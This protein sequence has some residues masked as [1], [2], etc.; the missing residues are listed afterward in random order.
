MIFSFGIVI[1]IFCPVFGVFWGFLYFCQYRRTLL[2]ALIIGVAIAAAFYGYIPDSSSDV[3][4]HIA[5]LKYYS[6]ISFFNCFDAGHYNKMYVWDIWCWLIAQMNNENMLQ[7]SGA[8]VGYTVSVY[9]IFDACNKYSIDRKT[10]RTLFLLLLCILP[11]HQFVCGLR[12]GNAFIICCLAFYL[13]IRDEKRNPVKPILCLIVAVLIHH[14][15]LMLVGLFF[16]F[17]ITGKKNNYRV[18]IIIFLS[19]LGIGLI[20]S[21][22]LRILPS[23]GNVA[24]SLIRESSLEATGHINDTRTWYVTKASSFNTRVN[25]YWAHMMII[26]LILRSLYA[27]YRIQENAEY[28]EINASMETRMRNCALINYSACLGLSIAFT[29]NGQRFLTPCLLVSLMS[30]VYGLKES[31]L[32]ISHK[33]KMQLIDAP[34]TMGAIGILLLHLYSLAYGT[35]SII[36]LLKGAVLGILN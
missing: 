27:S 26:M 3:T 20:S 32:Y 19:T 11:A 33:G 18:S 24:M 16:I 25:N 31:P 5:W 2:S 1:S 10:V 30:N 6:G 22:L 4:R 28:N 12:N 7:A 34:I 13:Y 36:S 8:L 14:S 35:G 9:M 21:Y 15:S 17:V 29:L 23:S